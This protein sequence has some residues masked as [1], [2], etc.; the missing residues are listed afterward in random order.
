MVALHSLQRIV[1]GTYRREH[2]GRF[3]GHLG[4][5]WDPFFDWGLNGDHALGMVD[6][7]CN[8]SDDTL[9]SV[10]LG[11]GHTIPNLHEFENPDRGLGD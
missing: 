5:P 10:R 6:R 9:V 2:G 4:D 1:R 3:D 8:L 11:D 7:Y